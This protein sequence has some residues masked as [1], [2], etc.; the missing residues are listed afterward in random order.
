M[1]YVNLNIDVQNLGEN[2]TPHFMRNPKFSAFVDVI[3]IENGITATVIYE[4]VERIWSVIAYNNQVGCFEWFLNDLFDQ[5]NRGITITN[6][7]AAD[8]LITLYLSG[9]YDPTPDTLS[10]SGEGQGWQ[11]YTASEIAT[12]N[13][14]NYTINVPNAIY[15]PLTG[16]VLEYFV[17]KVNKLAPAGKIYEIAGY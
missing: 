7:A 6:N 3:S 16:T 5:T 11:L 14:Y 2:L 9:E 8:S 4:S 17:A 12:L 13:Y 10:L 1:N 15:T